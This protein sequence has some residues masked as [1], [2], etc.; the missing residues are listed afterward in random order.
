LTR[1]FLAAVEVSEL[2]TALF[3]L[4]KEV[5][6]YMALYTIIRVYEIPASS[7]IEATERML[8]ALMLKSER[9]FHVR[10]YIR[11]PGEATGKGKP[12]DLRPTGWLTLIREQLGLVKRKPETK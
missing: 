12:V 8:E 5:V 7:R 9:D 1:K 11:E 6:L 4:G 2:E 10:D 3:Q